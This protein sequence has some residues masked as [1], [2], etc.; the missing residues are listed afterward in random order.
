VL[1]RQSGRGE[2]GLATSNDGLRWSYQRIILAEPFHMSY[3]YVFAWQSEFYL[4][5]ETHQASSVRLY[6]AEKF[7]GEWKPVVTLLSG[8]YFA[9][10]SPFQHDGRWWM[11]VETNPEKKHDTLRLFFSDD[12]QGPWREH[13]QSP[14][15]RQNPHIARPA[16]RVL[17]TGGRL[18]RLAQ[19][20]W[21]EYGLS[22]R[23]FEITELSPTV[24]AEREVCSGAILGPSGSG[25]S[26][27]GMHHLDAH[28]LPD[29]R[30]LAAV[31]GWCAG[32]E[33]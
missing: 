22:V 31:D 32:P 1:N 4:V 10:A 24:Y 11:L 3:P 14:V 23:A 20:C 8:G 5:P 19:D 16:G 29:G 28:L 26:E 33:Q 17:R 2:I 30:W 18:L 6:R 25:W 13:P 21:P 12:L 15:I 9:D 7:P 27:S